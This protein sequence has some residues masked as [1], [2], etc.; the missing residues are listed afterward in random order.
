MLNTAS[1]KM[2]KLGLESRVRN[3]QGDIMA[4]PFDNGEFDYV[5]CL[6]DALS[7]CPD[8]EKAFSELVRV[9]GDNGLLHLSVNSFWGNFAGFIGRGP[10]IGFSFDDVMEYYSSRIIHRNGVSTDCRSF[11]YRELR[12]MGSRNGLEVVKAFSAPVF[13]VHKKW[14][15]DK[16]KYEKV[17]ELQYRYC[18]DENL[19]DTGN[20]L[21]VIYKR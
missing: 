18:E 12:E 4:M 11:T 7:F 10:D 13:P 5:M 19:L 1:E 3:R 17:R 9:T 8:T 2:V 6:G 16:E 21:N 15:N 14:I 20:H